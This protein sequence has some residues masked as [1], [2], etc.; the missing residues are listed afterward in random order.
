MLEHKQYLLTGQMHGVV[1]QHL[2]IN[3]EN[4]KVQVSFLKSSKASVH[5]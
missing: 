3:P 1:Q 2:D 5:Y 4:L